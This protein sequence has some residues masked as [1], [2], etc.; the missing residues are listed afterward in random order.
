MSPKPS[1]VPHPSSTTSPPQLEAAKQV[2]PG[3]PGWRLPHEN[4]GARLMVSIQKVNAPGV[5]PSHI[6]S[7]VSHH[8]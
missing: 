6:T 4:P 1:K 7:Y 8:T 3:T 2:L 5:P